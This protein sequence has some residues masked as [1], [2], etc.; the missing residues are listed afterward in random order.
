MTVIDAYNLA[1]YSDDSLYVKDC[2]AWVTPVIKMGIPAFIVYVEDT[3]TKKY[4]WHHFLYK[5]KA[6]GSWDRVMITEDVYIILKNCWVL[7]GFE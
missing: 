4:S 7:G 6:N 2:N 3:A 5:R 1:F